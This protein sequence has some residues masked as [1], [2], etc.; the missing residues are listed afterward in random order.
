[1]DPNQESKYN[2][3]QRLKRNRVKYLLDLVQRY[4]NIGS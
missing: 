2:T 1:M 3:A 4:L